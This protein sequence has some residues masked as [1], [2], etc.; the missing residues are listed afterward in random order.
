MQ[1]ILESTIYK[2]DIKT[3]LTRLACL[4]T[5]VKIFTSFCKMRYRM[6]AIKR[7]VFGIVFVVAAFALVNLFLTK[8][9]LQR[10]EL[11]SEKWTSRIRYEIEGQQEVKDSI[12]SFLKSLTFQSN[13]SQLESGIVAS[14]F[15]VQPKWV[16]GKIKKQPRLLLGIPSIARNNE[17]YLFETLTLLVRK[18]SEE[19]LN[20]TVFLV[21]IADSDERIGLDRALK[22]QQ[23][24]E[25]DVDEGRIML[26]SPPN[27]LMPD[28]E[29][30]LFPNFGDSISRVKWRSK[31]NLDM[32]YLMNYMI[33]NYDPSYFL[34]MEDDVAPADEYDRLI[35]KFA[36]EKPTDQWSYCDFT[37]TVGG[38][39]KLFHRDSMR[40]FAL[41]LEIFWNAKPLDWLLWDLVRG[42]KCGY[43][44]KGDECKEKSN[45]LIRAYTPDIFIHKGKE[46]SRSNPAFG[47]S[48]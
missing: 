29:N 40:D 43:S 34:M 25:K 21:Y 32:K 6:T 12:S 10:K 3:R 35:L 24:F 31:Q 47:L 33:K 37:Q 5:V 8:Y 30:K 41:L 13:Y 18:L 39:G 16:R 45:L 27:V 4:Y 11:K 14:N 23:S 26:I 2:F 9:M 48:R 20:Q 15:D 44:D 1:E 7:S 36:G 22:I 19:N 46:S 42:K 17:D 28:W 38:A